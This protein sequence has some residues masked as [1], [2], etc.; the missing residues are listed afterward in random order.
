MAGLARSAMFSA[1]NIPGLRSPYE[2]VGGLLHF[3]RMLDKIRLHRAGQLPTDYLANLGGGFDGRLCAFLGVKYEDVVARVK[4]GGTDDDVLAWCFQDGRK[5]SDDE[6]EVMNDFLRKR[7]WNDDASDR[8]AERVK[9]LGAP[10]LGKV[11]TFFD[12]IEADEGRQP[13]SR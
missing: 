13:R 10:W 8:L 4:L 6:I 2:K 11:H 1:M 3:G 12:L 9:Q 7:G 5:P